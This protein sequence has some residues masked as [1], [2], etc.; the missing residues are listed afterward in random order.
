MPRLNT[1]VF[2]LPREHLI[3][4]A[5][6]VMESVIAAARR[7]WHRITVLRGR[8]ASPDGVLRAVEREDPA[9]FFGVGHGS[10]ERFTVECTELL[11]EACSP[12]AGT[13]AGRVVHLNSCWTGLRL[14]PDLIDKG[15]VAFLGSKFPF[16]FYIGSPPNSDRASRTAFIAEYAATAALM[17]GST[18]GEAHRRR[19]EAYDREIS[20]W[21]EGPGKDHP[22]AQLLARILIV[23][24]RYA[25]ML[26]DETARPGSRGIPALALA[27]MAVGMVVG[28]WASWRR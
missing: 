15:A 6:S 11:M 27:P 5:S 26:G 10:P 7:P 16:F 12:E 8:E 28:G 13:M 14:G 22:H 20:Y 17:L 2:A 19:L 3:V 4:Y 9:M 1:F 25:V 23:N 24:K 21:L 18:V